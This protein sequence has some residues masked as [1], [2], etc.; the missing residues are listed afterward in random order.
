MKAGIIKYHGLPDYYALL[1]DHTV[2]KATHL[3]RAEFITGFRDLDHCQYLKGG[4]DGK[5]ENDDD[6]FLKKAITCAYISNDG[7]FIM[8][9]PTPFLPLFDE[10]KKAVKYIT[11][12]EFAQKYN[13]SQTRVH[14]LIRQ[15]RIPGVV[16]IGEKVF[17][18]PEFTPYPE[19]LR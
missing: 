4:Q 11:V 10:T 1:P 9:D 15:D 3:I 19:S 17:G 2:S 18:I 8:F 13:V 12:K 7:D 5:W 6:P 14:A 16:R